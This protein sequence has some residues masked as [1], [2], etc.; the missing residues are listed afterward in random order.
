MQLFIVK[1]DSRSSASN[2]IL[3]LDINELRKYVSKHQLSFRGAQVHETNSEHSVRN[4]E[5]DNITMFFHT[6]N[7]FPSEK[8]VRHAL[9]S[10]NSVHV[11]GPLNIGAFRD[12]LRVLQSP[13]FPIHTY[14]DDITVFDKLREFVVVPN[15]LAVV[16]M[17]TS[18]WERY[19]YSLFTDE[20][21]TITLADETPPTISPTGR[22]S[23]SPV[24]RFSP[25]ISISSIAIG[26]VGSAS[27]RRQRL[28][29][30]A[31]SSDK[32]PIPEIRLNKKDTAF[33]ETGTEQASPKTEIVAA[34]VHKISVNHAEADKRVV[35]LK[36]RTKDKAQEVREVTSLARDTTGVEHELMQSVGDDSVQ[37]SGELSGFG[38]ESFEVSKTD[39]VGVEN[40]QLAIDR[41]P[42]LE[43]CGEVSEDEELVSEGMYA[44]PLDLDIYA[45]KC[46]SP[47]PPNSP[48]KREKADHEPI[49][50]SSAMMKLRLIAAA[51]QKEMMAYD[52]IDC[53]SSDDPAYLLAQFCLRNLNGVFVP[54]YVEEH[55]SDE[56]NAD[57]PNQGW[58]G[59]PVHGSREIFEKLS[60]SRLAS[61]EMISNVKPIRWNSK[62]TTYAVTIERGNPNL[63]ANAVSDAWAN[64]SQI[65]KRVIRAFGCS[66]DY[67]LE[68]LASRDYDAIL[69]LMSSLSGAC[70]A[71]KSYCYLQIV[72]YGSLAAPECEELDSPVASIKCYSAVAHEMHELNRLKESGVAALPDKLMLET[73]LRKLSRHFEDTSAMLETVSTTNAFPF[74]VVV[75]LVSMSG[76]GLVIRPIIG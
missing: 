1:L 31:K 25:S 38:D 74:R 51:F 17:D 8:S 26:E 61:M 22:D 16:D 60:E 64:H 65:S 27:K 71:T 6:S 36:G 40:K 52:K 43:P 14:G 73:Y 68:R 39:V 12:S 5:D 48:K 41:V 7:V 56:E 37:V 50:I 3:V 4:W 62:K 24:A 76:I 57:D 18:A 35:V 42:E 59:T 70:H 2:E 47:T 11:C 46:P 72:A 69:M 49:D 55:S 45:E 63:I 53:L 29:K 32:T 66:T 21:G 30:Q 54:E 75:L 34:T 58:N 15:S 44:V 33:A 20:P 10:R 23:V 67:C 19:T 13:Q 28:V 9:F